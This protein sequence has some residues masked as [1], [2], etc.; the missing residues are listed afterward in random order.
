[1]QRVVRFLLEWSHWAA[2]MIHKKGAKGGMALI[3]GRGTNQ[4]CYIIK[5]SYQAVT[6][7][8]T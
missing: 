1:M 5:L 2:N 6:P 8:S 7:G 4:T 3:K